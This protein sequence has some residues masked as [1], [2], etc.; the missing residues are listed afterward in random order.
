M[1]NIKTL[2][3]IIFTAS[4]NFV[5]AQDNLRLNNC[6]TG[7]GQNEKDFELDFSLEQFET[8]FLGLEGIVAFDI[9]YGI[10][11]YEQGINV[12][13]SPFKNAILMETRQNLFVGFFSFGFISGVSFRNLNH[14][15]VYYIKPNIILDL[16]FMKITYSYAFTSNKNLDYFNAG[17]NL[18]LRVPIFATCGFSKFIKEKKKLHWGHAHH[19]LEW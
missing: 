9:V 18:G 15:K 16:R 4:I 17:H 8:G 1:R 12:A 13:Y 6:V 11:F 19:G 5:N 7:D 14:D 3:L 10:G 2:I